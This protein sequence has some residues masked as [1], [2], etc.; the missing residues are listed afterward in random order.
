MRLDPAACPPAIVLANFSERDTDRLL[1]YLRDAKAQ[2]PIKAVVTPTSRSWSF[3]KLLIHLAE[4]HSA[5]AA[6]G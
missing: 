4:E 2:I 1:R 3:G 6:Q 5:Y